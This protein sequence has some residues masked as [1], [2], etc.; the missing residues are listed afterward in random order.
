MSNLVPCTSKGRSK[1]FCTTHLLFVFRVGS[2]P[3]R[4][5]IR[6]RRR[7][8][9]I[10]TR[11]VLQVSQD[12][13]IHH[14]KSLTVSNFS[15]LPLD[16]AAGLMIQM[17]SVPSMSCCGLTSLS[18]CSMALQQVTKRSLFSIS[19]PSLSE[20]TE[21]LYTRYSIALWFASLLL[22]LTQ[23]S[24]NSEVVTVDE[25][26]PLLLCKCR[27]CLRAYVNVTMLQTLQKLVTYFKCAIKHLR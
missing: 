13:V 19:T 2:P 27:W 17:L 25:L 3:T 6:S 5:R 4:L 16:F 14:V 10:P 8:H 15:P 22:F 7:A 18:L 20:E 26:C 12:Y 24:L 11:Q 23:Y 1:Y 21:R 9:L